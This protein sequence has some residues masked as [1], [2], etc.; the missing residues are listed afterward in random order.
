MLRGTQ[1][2]RS[3]GS[4]HSETLNQLNPKPYKLINGDISAGLTICV[5]KAIYLTSRHR[6]TLRAGHK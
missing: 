1:P 6:A 5:G 3:R 4:P 2:A